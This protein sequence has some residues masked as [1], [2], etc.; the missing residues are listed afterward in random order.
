MHCVARGPEPDG[1]EAIREKYT[2]GWMRRYPNGK[3]SRPNDTHWRDFRET[4]RKD[5][6]GLCG[7]C[8]ERTKGEVDHF[9]PVSR[10]PKQVYQW[11]NRIFSCTACNRAN[12]AKWP[13]LGYVDPCADS[14]A[15][16]PEAYFTFGTLNGMIRPRAGLSPDRHA[17]AAT[18]IRDLAL[19]GYHHMQNRVAAV[20]RLS[21]ME[22]ISVSGHHLSQEILVTTFLRLSSRQ[23]PWS[24]VIR[25]WLLE[26]GY[27]LLD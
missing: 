11:S 9:R 7:Y 18:M 27:E 21:Q 20:Q 3:G 23:E 14:E 25:V 22:R 24:S 13:P 16:R 6:R 12:G 2:A 19:N 26:Q 1:L 4:L 15:E 5:F 10:F 17:R 8:E